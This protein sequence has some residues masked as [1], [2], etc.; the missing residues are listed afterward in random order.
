MPPVTNAQVKILPKKY[1]LRGQMETEQV[2]DLFLTIWKNKGSLASAINNINVSLAAGAIGAAGSDGDVQFNSLGLMQANSRLNF[3]HTGWHLTLR[4]DGNGIIATNPGDANYQDIGFG[5]EYDPN[6]GDYIPENTS[7]SYAW[8]QPSK[9]R[10]G[11][12]LVYGETAGVASPFAFGTGW[13]MGSADSFDTN[14]KFQIY[15]YGGLGTGAAA[16]GLI[17]QVQNNDSGGGAAA[18]LSLL[19]KNDVPSYVWIDASGFFRFHTAPPAESAGVSDTVASAYSLAPLNV[20]LGAAGRLGWTG[21]SRITS[22]AD[23]VV[24]LTDDAAADFSLLKFGGTTSSFPAWKRSSA[25]LVARLA[26]DSAD[27]ALTALSLTAPTVQGSTSASG[28]LAIKSTSNATK[29]TISMDSPLTITADGQYILDLVKSATGGAGGA[30]LTATGTVPQFLFVGEWDV[31]AMNCQFDGRSYSG[32]HVNAGM[33]FHGH[34][35]RGTIASPTATQSGDNLLV[36]AGGGYQ[37]GQVDS[38]A[39]LVMS[40]IENWT[41]TARGTRMVLSTTPATTNSPAAVITLETGVQIGAPTG[42]DKGAGTLNCQG[43]IYKQ[44]TAFTNPDY[45]FEHAFTGKVERFAHKDGARTYP[46]LQPLDAVRQEVREGFRFKRVA[47]AE[48]VFERADALLEK[49][50]EAY[51]YIFQLS[52][53]ISELEGRHGR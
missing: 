19:D 24:L 45:V 7:Y 33:I 12:E 36:F 50:E 9:S 25:G 48:G 47:Q 53:R 3:D 52:D 29:G 27:A 13:Q 18:A 34:A 6:T 14:R 37:G 11:W 44:G 51:L 35:I 22:P 15:Q 16:T 32:T 21:R 1:T 4:G 20:V 30:R 39:T 43:D 26:D 40:A 41:A 42:G 2:E 46:G 10:F 49:L 31:A 38:K 8:S 5:L 23:S 28:T 17:L